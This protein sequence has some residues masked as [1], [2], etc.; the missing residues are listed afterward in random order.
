MWLIHCKEEEVWWIKF[1]NYT[2][3]FSLSIAF[4]IGLLRASLPFFVV[5]VLV[6]SSRFHSTLSK[7]T[8]N[9]IVG[10][11][12]KP[13]IALIWSLAV[14]F[15]SRRSLHQSWNIPS[16][17]IKSIFLEFTTRTWI[18]R[19]PFFELFKIPFSILYWFKNYFQLWGSYFAKNHKHV[20]PTSTTRAETCFFLIHSDVWD[21]TPEF[22]THGFLYYVSFIDDCTRMR[23]LYF[24]KRKS[25]VNDSFDN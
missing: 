15:M 19:S 17:R 13:R 23:W 14:Q 7:N 12:R 6:C 8:E 22:H 21:P 2:K 9:S 11:R 5:Q 1:R 16:F 25:E 24:L 3:C 4:A 10:R 20:Y 18:T